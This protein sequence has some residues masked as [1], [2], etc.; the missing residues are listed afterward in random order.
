ML[1]Q[2]TPGNRE[3][4]YFSSREQEALGTYVYCLRDPRDKKIFYVGQGTGDRVFQHFSDAEACLNGGSALDPKILRILE[5]WH[6]EEDV[7]WRILARKLGDRGAIPLIDI[8]ESVVIDA[9]S[10]SQNGSPLNLISGKHS[11]ALSPEDLRVMDA[12]PVNPPQPYPAVFLFPIQNALANGCSPYDATRMSWAISARYRNISGAVAV[13][14]KGA[15]SFGSFKV[16][17]WLDT[18][19]GKQ[20]FEGCDYPALFN[21]NWV[22]IISASKGYW[23]RGNYLIIE[24]DGNGQ[25][26]FLRGNPDLSWRLLIGD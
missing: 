26:R 19:N 24:F 9:L 13:G 7:E 25:F 20:L 1:S 5:I 22:K 8:V 2:I 17:R 15:I 23:Q 16:E 11:S 18:D 21:K 12:M 3:K 6:V 14:I 4:R 10:E